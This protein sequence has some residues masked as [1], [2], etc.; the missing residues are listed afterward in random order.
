MLT[1]NNP[2][3]LAIS[4]F[5]HLI[6][7]VVWIGALVTMALVVWPG[8]RRALSDEAALARAIEAIDA[9]LKPL[10]NLSLIVLILTG[11]VQLNSNENYVGLL[12]FS[13]TWA[14]AIALKH[15]SI[16]GMV[17]VGAAL[18]FGVQPALRRQALLAAAGASDPAEAAA[19]RRQM[20]RLG[21]INLILGVVV[22]VFTAIARA[23]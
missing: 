22:L 7:T 19:L 17:G 11:F 9:R 10:A 3:L 18:N 6:A 14:Q 8:L 1:L 23:Q 2:A 5:L 20:N 13:N 12:N 16:I 4:Y 21:R 15:L